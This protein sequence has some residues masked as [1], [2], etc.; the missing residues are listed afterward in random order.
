M[1]RRE[2]GVT[3]SHTVELSSWERSQP[4]SCP[5]RSGALWHLPFCP[6]SQSCRC[7]WV[8]LLPAPLPLGT[9]AY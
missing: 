5:L 9:A 4:L 8:T 3:A 7:R 1:L 6:H 2:A